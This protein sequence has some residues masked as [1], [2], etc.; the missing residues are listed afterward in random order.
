MNHK[1]T[2]LVEGAVTE[3]LPNTLFRVNIDNAEDQ[4]L[5]NTNV[6]CHLSGKMRMHYIRV[7]P[8]DR[9]RIEMTP[10]D[11]E[12]GRIVFRIK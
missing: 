2:F 5:V 8:G 7:M 10:Y 11:K 3:A 4:E 6:L 9:V 12:K 1:G